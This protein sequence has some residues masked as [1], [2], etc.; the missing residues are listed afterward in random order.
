MYLTFYL[1]A[2][3]LSLLAAAVIFWH[4]PTRADDNQSTRALEGG[5][6]LF[7]RQMKYIFVYFLKGQDK[8][9]EALD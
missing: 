2:G 1:F 9:K 6:S 8:K 3:I 5:V 7:S 4:H